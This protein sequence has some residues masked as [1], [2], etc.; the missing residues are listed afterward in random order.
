[1]NE[2]GRKGGMHEEEWETLMGNEKVL[3]EWMSS[4]D[5]NESGG[6]S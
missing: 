3:D 4:D 2:W 1:M 5:K 6:M